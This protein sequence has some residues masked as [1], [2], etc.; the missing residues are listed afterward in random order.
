MVISVREDS[1]RGPY[2]GFRVDNEI[3]ECSECTEAAAYRLRHTEDEQRNPAEHR[4]AA[5][6]IIEAEYPSHS[7]EIRVG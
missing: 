3:L 5:H 2:I 6:R 1:E 4:F 7:D